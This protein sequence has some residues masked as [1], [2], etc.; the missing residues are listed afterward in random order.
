[1]PRPK[2]FVHVFSG[3]PSP[4]DFRPGEGRDEMEDSHEVACSEGAPFPRF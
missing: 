4:G 2:E 1:V 3:S